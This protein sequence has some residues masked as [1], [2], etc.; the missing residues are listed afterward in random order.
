MN[1]SMVKLMIIGRRR[2]G[3]TLLQHR[4][5]I[6]DVHGTMVLDYVAID[7][8]NAPKRYAQN[9]VYDGTFRGTSSATDAFAL[10]C[11]FVN[12]IWFDDLPSIDRSRQQPFYIEQLAP[13]EDNFVDQANVTMMPV[14][15]REVGAAGSG[16]YKVF[17]CLS[18][19]PGSSLDAFRQAWAGLPSDLAASP[20]AGIVRREVQ[21]D[22]LLRPEQSVTPLDG[23]DEFW[24]D[25]E[26][27]AAQLVTWLQD[28][29]ANTLVAQGLVDA[30][31]PFTVM[32]REYPL[33]N[34]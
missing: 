24:L 13:D 1:Q 12:E 5:H 6:K 8:A 7:P 2:P 31:M 3:T 25:D 22:V 15:E 30:A 27:S 33:H 4:H 18:R 11:D 26:V 29:L 32:A 28:W 9:H 20:L 19:Q 23:I 10:N 14:S 34:G 21:N 17:L 16:A